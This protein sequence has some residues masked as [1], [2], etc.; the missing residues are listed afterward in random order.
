M[1]LNKAVI[2]KKLEFPGGLEVKDQ[3]FSFQWCDNLFNPWPWEILHAIGMAK[4]KNYKVGFS[5]FCM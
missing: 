4:K 2:T 1:C 3:A 5:N